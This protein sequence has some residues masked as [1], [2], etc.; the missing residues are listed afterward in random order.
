MASAITRSAVL[1]ESMIRIPKAAP[2]VGL[3]PVEKPAILPIAHKMPGI[4]RRAKLY[5]GS[6]AP[7][8]VQML[9]RTIG[10]R[11]VARLI[12]PRPR[13]TIQAKLTIGAPDDV[14]EREADSVAE[15]VM[16][17]ST[18]QRKCACGGDSK[19]EEVC[20]DCQMSRLA[21]QRLRSNGDAGPQAPSIV[22]DVLATPGQPLADSV[23]RTLEPAFGHDFS[24]VRVHDG[25]RESES[26]ASVGAKAYTVGNHIVFGAGQHSPGTSEGN[27]LLAHELTHTIQQT[28][29]VQRACL[30]AAACAVRPG[31]ASVFG[32]NVQTAEAAAR[33]RRAAMSPARQ[34]ASGHAGPAR[35]LETFF[36]SQAPGLLAKI[37]GI[38]VDQD[39]DPHVAA[40]T[41]EC[42]SMVPPILGATKL[43]VFVPPQLNQEALTF[44]TN[45]TAA[46]IGGR[47][48][49]DWRIET[50][51][52]LTHE[53]Q[54]VQY[55]TAKAGAAN[56]P[57]TACARTD[58]EFELSELNAILSEFPAV[59]DAVP[60]GAPAGDPAQVRLDSWFRSS[61]TNSGESIR[62]ILQTVDCKCD[63]PDT[64]AY[65]RETVA[66]V[67]GSWTAAQKNA[68]NTE[69]RKPIWALRWPL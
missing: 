51:Q 32:G 43:C 65:I 54:H 64:D 36:N 46:T 50:L 15:H 63:C 11:A 56:P 8:E 4:L 55:D 2:R 34:V 28:G 9:Q 16:K 31:S 49:E 58:V 35:Q 59:F 29:G 14:Y 5:D 13:L 60:I 44:N 53:V 33:A 27:H 40:S 30:P 37:Q 18:I 42:N 38:F 25:P 20:P 6:L 22:E 69:L 61:I 62:G 67:T 26:A 66:F 45:P 21:L 68:L 7:A 52:T 39:M 17:S 47:P 10:N 19:E 23:R 57:G 41:Q 24:Q 3:Q 12:E 48:R 1:D